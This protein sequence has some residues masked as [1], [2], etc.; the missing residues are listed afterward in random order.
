[1]RRQNTSDPDGGYSQ[2]SVRLQ[3]FF[4]ATSL[5]IGSGVV[6]ATRVGKLLFTALHNLTGRE[7]AGSCKS[8]ETAGVPDRI[9][10]RGRIFC[11]G[12]DP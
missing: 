10:I 4:G 9:E 2:H 8:K 12:G 5:A 6:V 11:R 1:M 3:M 7:P